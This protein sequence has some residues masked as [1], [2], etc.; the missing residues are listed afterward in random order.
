MT[1]AQAPLPLPTLTP[2][3][4]SL[5]FPPAMLSSCFLPLK[6]NKHTPTS[7][8]LQQLFPLP[9]VLSIWH[10]LGPFSYF[11]LLFHLNATP[12][13]RALL[14]RHYLKEHPF[15]TS[16]S[17]VPRRCFISPYNIYHH[18]TLVYIYLFMVCLSQYIAN[19]TRADSLVLFI[20]LA[21]A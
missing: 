5:L 15:P 8:V 2:D 4:P 6:A 1:G 12:P 20:A 18:L 14:R 21:Q 3:P 13:R 17:S 11:I 10:S 9:A 7:G 19:F 16:I